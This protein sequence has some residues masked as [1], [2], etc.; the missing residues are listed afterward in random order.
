[1]T[2]GVS[3]AQCVTAAVVT[4]NACW[5]VARPIA[6]VAWPKGFVSAPDDSPGSGIAAPRQVLLVG[7]PITV[8][9]YREW[10]SYG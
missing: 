3:P 7:D 10:W 8:G 2:P 6:A 4:T 1:M 5:I 9:R